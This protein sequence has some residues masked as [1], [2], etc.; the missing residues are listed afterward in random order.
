MT[1]S[2]TQT[3]AAEDLVSKQTSQDPE[4]CSEKDEA[5]QNMSTC[6]EVIL[7][8]T[9]CHKTYQSSTELDNHI[10]DTHGCHPPPN[11]PTPEPVE[12]DSVCDYCSDVFPTPELLQE[13]LS[14]KHVTDY[15]SCDSC[16][17]RFQTKDDQTAH[18]QACHVA[19]PAAPDQRTT[20][21][22]PT[23]DSD[24]TP[25]TVPSSIQS[26]ATSSQQL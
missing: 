15:I 16:K 5:P 1:D 7:T 10:E 14:T 20:C 26:P 19:P 2:A 22:S 12:S 17:L 9:I 4:E 6:S 23:D 11:S 3:A 21:P 8:C 18:A 25:S 24:L 13:H